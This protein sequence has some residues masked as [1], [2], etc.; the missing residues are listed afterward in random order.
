MPELESDFSVFHGVKNIYKMYAPV[1]NSRMKYLGC[2]AGAIQ[3]AIL[4]E[5]ENNGN[6]GNSGNSNV[7]YGERKPSVPP[8]VLLA[9]MGFKNE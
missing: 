6:S 9:S 1:F 5:Q 2:Y 3:N 4:N 7:D 8:D